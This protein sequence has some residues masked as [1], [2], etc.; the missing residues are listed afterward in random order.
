MYYVEG[1]ANEDKKCKFSS[2]GI[3]KDNDITKERFKK[4]LTDQSYKDVWTNK[5]FR[6]IDNYMMI[7]Y[8]QMSYY[9]DKR[10]IQSNVI[11]TLPW[12]I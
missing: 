12:P 3:Q 4:V 5:G 9:Y 10:V 1:A 11:D 8:T 7:T 2:K 6:V